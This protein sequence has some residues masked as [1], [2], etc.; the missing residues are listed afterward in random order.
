MRQMTKYQEIRRQL[1]DHPGVSGRE[2]YAHDIIVA[3]LRK[4]NATTIYDHVGGYGVVA[5]W[6][7]ANPEATTLA[8]RA[9]TDALPI[10]HRCGHDGHTAV[11]LRFADVVASVF[12]NDKCFK[13]N[14]LLIFQPEEETGAGARK[15]VESGI[16]QR[17]GVKSVF[18]M[19]NLPGYP[20]G[21][22]VLNRHTFAAASTGVVYTLQGRETHA[23]TPEKGI[24]P[25]LAIARI[26]ERFAGLNVKT[27]DLDAF[28]QSTLICCRVGEEAFGTSAGRGE[29]M[30]TL[31]AYTNA[32]MESLL[33]D[34]D[35][36][37][38]NVVGAA[39][40][41][42]G[43]TWR[44]ELREPFKATENTTELVDRLESVF[45]DAMKRDAICGLQTIDTPFRW[46]EDFAEYLS[47]FPGVFFG[48]GSGENQ[49][50]LHHPDYDFPDA[51][52]EPM[53]RCFEVLLRMLRC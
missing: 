32:A 25:G 17:H 14:V 38:A 28:R 24:N 29:V 19:H 22:A 11:M 12:E 10:G 21:C 3:E 37:V 23:S 26:I 4:T 42:G 41:V 44:R 45:D 46:S 52:I 35:T 30:F 43:M 27:S 50:E 49:P 13:H 15:I 40:P 31:R 9:D 39:S 51:L 18:G 1:H 53:S 16:M 20:L 6:G 47:V 2:E 48:V 5:Y 34:A 36:I 7:S 8:F 33:N